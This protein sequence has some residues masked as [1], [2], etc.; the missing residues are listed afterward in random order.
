MYIPHIVS[1]IPVIITCALVAFVFY[2][3]STSFRIPNWLNASILALCP[4]AFLLHANMPSV[5]SSI[6]AFVLIFLSVGAFFMWARNFGGGD[7]K[8]L[9]ALA[10]W[11]G[12]FHLLDFILYMGVFGG[13]ETLSIL[14]LR[15]Y[16]PE[17]SGLRKGRFKM[18]YSR[19]DIPYG[20]AIATAA[21]IMLFYNFV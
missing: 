12:L 4:V 11:I 16:T 18:L 15:K 6:G 9:S 14:L 19:N 5:I 10:P 2:T 3:D 7:W 20:L 8:M 13:I 21:L 17:N 1:D